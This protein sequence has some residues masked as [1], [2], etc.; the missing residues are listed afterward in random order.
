MAADVERA[1]RSVIDENR[2]MTIA[3]ADADG[4]PWA[5]PVWYA[6]TDY[7]EF[8]WVS[9][10]DARHSLNIA[11]RPYVG[12]VIF[13]SHMPGGWQSV[14]M[15]ARAEV[16]PEPELERTIGVFTARSEA[17][18]LPGWTVEDVREPAKH[19]LYRAT[20]T[21]RFVLAEGDQRVAL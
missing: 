15:T 11:A 16:V 14:Y 1:A 4:V 18:G 19:R 3:S 13:D 12:I 21:E 2:Y 5:S 10:P 17:Q 7:R 6:H 9:A 20:A 8:I